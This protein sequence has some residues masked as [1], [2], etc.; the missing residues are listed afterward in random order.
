MGGAIIIVDP[1]VTWCGDGQM[2]IIMAISA[3][4]VLIWFFC[5]LFV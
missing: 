3:M 2:M 1:M 5:I 4:Y